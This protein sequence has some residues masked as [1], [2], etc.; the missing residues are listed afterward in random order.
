MGPRQELYSNSG[1]NSRLEQ[2][3]VRE[4]VRKGALFVCL[5]AAWCA[6]WEDHRVKASPPFLYPVSR[7]P[8]AASPGSWASRC[9][10][11]TYMKRSGGTVRKL[12]IDVIKEIIR[13]Q[14]RL[15]LYEPR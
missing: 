14:K 8:W 2:P 1:M 15:R 7:I 10:D 9:T 4:G 6:T 3:V 12:Y 13:T 5:Y 11:F